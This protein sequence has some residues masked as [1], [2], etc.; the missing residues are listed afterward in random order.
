M[1]GTAGGLRAARR[2]P[3]PARRNFRG[4]RIGQYT[5]R[6]RAASEFVLVTAACEPPAPVK[7]QRTSCAG[8]FPIAWVAA[9]R[10]DPAAII[11][12]RPGLHAPWPR[13]FSVAEARLECRR[14][15]TRPRLCGP[16]PCRNRSSD[17]GCGCYTV[18]FQNATVNVWQD[19][20]FDDRRVPSGCWRLLRSWAEGSVSRRT[21]RGCDAAQGCASDRLRDAGGESCNARAAAGVRA[22]FTNTNTRSELTGRRGT[23]AQRRAERPFRCDVR[24][25][26]FLLDARG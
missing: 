6:R 8:T 21:R 20:M 15:R 3:H 5:F 14:K 18:P 23:I 9:S 25:G 24:D 7:V 12:L 2:F 1:N 16:W 19:V 11:R 17:C 26:S 4:T 22:R 10:P 13:L